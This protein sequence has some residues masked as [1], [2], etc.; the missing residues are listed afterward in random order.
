MTTKPDTAWVHYD[1][2]A[3]TFGKLLE[4]GSGDGV[5]FNGVGADND[6]TISIFNFIKRGS[7]SGRANVLHQGRD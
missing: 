4:I 3:A 7:H 5:V 6:G 1:H 2:V